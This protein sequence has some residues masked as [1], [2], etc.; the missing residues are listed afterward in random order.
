MVKVL[1]LHSEKLH[2]CYYLP[3]KCGYMRRPGLTARVNTRAL[4]TRPDGKIPLIVP[5]HG[6]ED[7]I[8]IDLGE[9]GCE[10]L[11]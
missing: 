11:D 2:G 9:L 1:V 6:L 10:C 8:K 7:N 3:V 5:M 4:V